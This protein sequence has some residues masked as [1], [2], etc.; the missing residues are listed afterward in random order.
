MNRHY[1]AD[2]KLAIWRSGRTQQ[3]VADLAGIDRSQLSH[4]I[5]G[6]RRLLP[7]EQ[8]QLA[9]VLHTTAEAL[10]QTHNQER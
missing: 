7:G 8:A 6:R 2:L 1:N 3:R 4:V 5:A 9:K 10:F